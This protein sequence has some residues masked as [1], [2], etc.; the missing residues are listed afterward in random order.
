MHLTK[1][2]GNILILF[3]LSSISGLINAETLKVSTIDWC[4][5][6]C[7]SN[8]L[9]G[10]V[11]DTVR[12]VFEGSPYELMT[13]T[14]PWTRAIK[15]VEKGDYHALL[16]PA[17]AEAPGLLF[18][19][20]EIGVQRMCFFTKKESNWLYSGLESLAGLKIG[21]ANDTSI[22][23]L[24]KYMKQNKKQFD[25]L[26]Y[27]DAYLIKSF[28]KLEAGRVDTFIFT[29]NSAVYEMKKM[30]V[31]GKYR[32][33]GCV[34]I[35]KIYMAFT[36]IASKKSVVEKMMNY[37]DFRMGS[38]KKSGELAKIMQRYQLED[39]QIFL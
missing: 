30:G 3:A 39:W 8:E 2:V 16:S 33:A 7:P 1:M 14:Y 34:S 32:S 12:M 29:Y 20:H 15:L 10:Y 26:P 6:L 38:L 35:A 22:E 5:Q 28:R 13:R 25:F 21:V 31:Y 19:M 37:F 11:M 9:P 24:N 17:K 18:P 4:P 23:E 27:N 36:P